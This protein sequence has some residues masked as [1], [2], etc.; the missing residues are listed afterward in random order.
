MKITNKMKIAVIIFLS[1]LL[2]GTISYFI[3]VVPYNLTCGEKFKLYVD[4]NRHVQTPLENEIGGNLGLLMR[5]VRLENPYEEGSILYSM[6]L[7][8]SQYNIPALILASLEIP[9]TNIAFIHRDCIHL[10]PIHES[11]HK[12]VNESFHCSRVALKEGGEEWLEY[13]KKTARGK[14][15]VDLH[16]TG[17]SIRSYWHKTFQEEPDLLFV[18]GSLPVG[19]LLV[20]T[21]G[22][23]SDSIERFNS[24]PLGSLLKF[25]KR[26]ENEF[27]PLV[28]ECQKRAVDCALSNMS[29]S[30]SPSLEKLQRVVLLMENSITVK[31]NTHIYYHDGEKPKTQI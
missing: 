10:Q 17:N 2:F 14:T 19:R 6:W 12:T 28:L 1:I 15:I 18:A 22:P 4:L 31:T 8:Q 16:G 21:S 30:F 13:V 23:S 25:P 20:N 5:Y 27:N 24:S 9:S 29:F 11:I 7:E 3:F 26:K